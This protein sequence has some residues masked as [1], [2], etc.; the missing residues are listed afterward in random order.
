MHESSGSKS[1]KFGALGLD[2]SPYRR[3]LELRRAESIKGSSLRGPWTIFWP[4]GKSPFEEAAPKKQ[5]GAM[6]FFIFQGHSKRP[7]GDSIEEH[8]TN[9]LKTD[10]MQVVV[11]HSYRAWHAL[12]RLYKIQLTRR[13]SSSAYCASSSSTYIAKSN[14][15][16]K[17]SAIVF[18]FYFYSYDEGR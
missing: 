4:D 16:I 18:Y 17:R 12:G 1:T 7:A 14:A 3:R 6:F 9:N 10:N 2:P 11:C 15:H 8:T 13:A 5:R